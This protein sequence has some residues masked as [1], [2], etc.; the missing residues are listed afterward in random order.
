MAVAKVLLCSCFVA[1]HWKHV[2]SFRQLSKVSNNKANATNAEGDTQVPVLPYF[3]ET[4]TSGRCGFIYRGVCGASRCC[5]SQDYC[6]S[7]SSSYSHMPR[8]CVDGHNIKKYTQKTVAECAQI[9]DSTEGCAG[10]EYGVSYGGS[11]R[12]RPGDC[13]PNSIAD[14]TGCDGAHHNLDFYSASGSGGCPSR[15]DGTVWHDNWRGICN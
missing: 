10:F 9:C 6:E 1:M 15:P 2:V 14:T 4:S 3:C 11:G 12:Y 8:S 13:Q 5:N 7:K